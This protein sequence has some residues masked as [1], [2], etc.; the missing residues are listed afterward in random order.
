MRQKLYPP[1]VVTDL[2]VGQESGMPVQFVL[3]DYTAVIEGWELRVGDKQVLL[4]D[5]ELRTLGGLFLNA[6]RLRNGAME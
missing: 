2:T 3:R 6:I 5:H 1:R 4:S